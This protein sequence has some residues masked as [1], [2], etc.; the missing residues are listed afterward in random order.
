MFPPIKGASP[1]P[2]KI[3]KLEP[4]LNEEKA[5]EREMVQIQEA[6]I[7]EESALY[8]PNLSIKDLKHDKTDQ[9]SRLMSPSIQGT[10]EGEGGDQSSNKI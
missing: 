5:P 8:E 4:A 3:S 9:G 2:Q 1:P 6:D 7:Q 10:V